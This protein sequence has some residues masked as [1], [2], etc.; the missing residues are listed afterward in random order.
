VP[1]TSKYSNKA[2]FTPQDRR[3]YGRAS[4]RSEKWR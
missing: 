4:V 2:D 3:E 1:T